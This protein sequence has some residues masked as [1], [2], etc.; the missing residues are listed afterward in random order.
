MREN[1]IV[2]APCLQV[3]PYFVLKI[4]RSHLVEDTLMKVLAAPPGDYRKQ[5]KIVFAGEPG[6]DEG[7]QLR[8]CNC[9]VMA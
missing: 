5:L 9:V 1:S 2:N 4:R 3:N 8:P 7:D 6:M